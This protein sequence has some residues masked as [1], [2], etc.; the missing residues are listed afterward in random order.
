MAAIQELGCIMNPISLM[1]KNPEMTFCKLQFQRISIPMWLK[2]P[3]GMRSSQWKMD[4]AK[5]NIWITLQS[6]WVFF[7]PMQKEFDIYD[8]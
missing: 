8:I 7:L 4:G 3:K 5:L 2:H 1:S 6:R